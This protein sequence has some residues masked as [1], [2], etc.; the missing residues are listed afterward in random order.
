MKRRQLWSGIFF[1]G[2][3]FISGYLIKSA[4]SNNFKFCLLLALMVISVIIDGL[5]FGDYIRNVPESVANRTTAL[6]SAGILITAFVGVSHEFAIYLHDHKLKISK[7]NIEL[8]FLI[9]AILS[10][11]MISA[12]SNSKQD[13]KAKKSASASTTALFT[14]GTLLSE[15]VGVYFFD[16]YLMIR[17]I[18]ILIILM[19]GTWKILNL[20]K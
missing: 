11:I 17:V 6:A 7:S 18:P 3:L 12:L 19:G 1:T 15:I 2:I 13:H 8:L 4:T 5:I 9:A 14:V 10:S 16:P 20:Q